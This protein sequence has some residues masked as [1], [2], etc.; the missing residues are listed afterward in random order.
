MALVKINPLAARVRWD[1]AADRPRQIRLADHRELA[2]TSLKAVR[3]ELAAY[4][5]GRGPRVT[6]L[7]ET[8]RGEA[9]L[10]YDARRRCWYLEAIDE[11]A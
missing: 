5:A 2:V 11:A 6:Y 9:S 1:R 3:D 7:L 4:P 10:V 8:E